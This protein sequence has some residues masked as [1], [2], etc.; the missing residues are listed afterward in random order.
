METMG[1][2]NTAIAKIGGRNQRGVWLACALRDSGC[3]E[4]EAKTAMLN[5]ASRVTGEKKEPYTDAEALRTL[6][7][8]YSKKKG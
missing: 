3:T 1:L 6:A 4:D 7:W 2:V 5:Y 8:A